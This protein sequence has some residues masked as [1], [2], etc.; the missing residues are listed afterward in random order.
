MSAGREPVMKRSYA[1]FADYHQFYLRDEERA[2]SEPSAFT[3]ADTEHRIRTDPFV[4][5][6]QPERN[7]SVPV[8]VEI[9]EGAPPSAL[10][11]WDHVA[12][13]SLDRPSGRLG[14]EECMGTRVG[15][16][17]LAFGTCRV[18]L[19]CAGLASSSENGLEGDDRHA[20][21]LSSARFAEV[22]VLKP[23]V[24]PRTVVRAAVGSATSRI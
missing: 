22:S 4:V 16:F 8:E 7:T 11:D 20:L 18:R 21:A 3:R 13:A 23:F 1:I 24:D 6:V 2:P 12:E 15:A 19:C 9:T 17:V 5:I 10:D 14:I